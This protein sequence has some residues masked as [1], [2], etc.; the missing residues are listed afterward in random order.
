[1]ARGTQR[2]TGTGALPRAGRWFGYDLRRKEAI[3]STVG[4]RCSS[5]S[6]WPEFGTTNPVTLSAAARMM[7][8]IVGPSE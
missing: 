3:A 6:Q 8:A 1:M 4:P 7:T 5:I 2:N